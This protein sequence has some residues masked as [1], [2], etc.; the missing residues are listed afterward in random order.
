MPKRRF[1]VL[2]FALGLA[3]LLGASA[4]HRHEAH[5]GGM[6]GPHTDCY[7]C[8]SGPRR[9]G[10]RAMPSASTK[11]GVFGFDET[12]SVRSFQEPSFV[13]R[14]LPFGRAPPTFF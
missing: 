2:A 9:D 10:A 6:Y 11:G 12:P 5:G 1:D 13:Q 14:L 8:F 4:L 3:L 7:M